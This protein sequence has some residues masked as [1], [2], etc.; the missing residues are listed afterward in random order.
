MA[1]LQYTTTLLF[2]YLGK[3]LSMS[4]FLAFFIFSFIVAKQEFGMPLA[5]IPS[6]T[7]LSRLTELT[8][9]M[10]WNL[11][12]DSDDSD[13]E[14]HDNST[15]R[16]VTAPGK[17]KEKYAEHI[18]RKATKK[19]AAATTQPEQ[20]GHT[21]KDSNDQNHLRKKIYEIYARVVTIEEVDEEETESKTYG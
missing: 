13:E 12:D 21:Q 2:S 17:K 11:E 7:D 8:S 1:S 14:D 20:K 16:N 18:R 4:F 15:S 10:K 3:N 9:D 6:T 19:P 5:K